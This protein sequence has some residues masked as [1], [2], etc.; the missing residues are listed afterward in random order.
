MDIFLRKITKPQHIYHSSLPKLDCYTKQFYFRFVFHFP[1]V[2]VSFLSHL[3][4]LWLDLS[5]SPYWYRILCVLYTVSSKRG[6]HFEKKKKTCWEVYLIAWSWVENIWSFASFLQ[7]R[8][9]LSLS[10]CIG[11]WPEWEEPLI[12][13][14]S[15]SNW[16]VVGNS[17]KHIFKKKV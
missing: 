16:K 3:C 5:R 10:S 2:F 6:I 7:G 13:F 1:Q 12:G 4:L 14:S 17:I 8:F 9:F 11:S 15:E